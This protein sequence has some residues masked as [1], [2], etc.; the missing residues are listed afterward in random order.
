MVPTVSVKSLGKRTY[1]FN[2]FTS[3]P[4]APQPSNWTENVRLSMSTHSNLVQLIACLPLK[5]YFCS[6]LICCL[7]ICLAETFKLI[8]GLK[9]LSCSDLYSD[10]VSGNSMCKHLP[11]KIGHL[12]K[13]LYLELPITGRD[14]ICGWS[15]YIVLNH[16]F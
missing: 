4:L 11:Q 7:A 10:I 15:H 1:W 12:F 3:P 5:F 9:F 16:Y 8:A 6:Q 2:S 14:Y 13:A